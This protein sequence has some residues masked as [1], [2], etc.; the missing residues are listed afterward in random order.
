MF[1]VLTASIFFSGQVARA[2]SGW[3]N[4]YKKAQEEAKAGNKILLLNFTGSDWCGWCIKF[5]R[6]VLSQPQFKEFARNNLVLVELDF[7]RVKTQSAELQKQNRQLAQQYEVVG[8]PTIIAL[9]SDGQKLWEYDGYFAG[10]PE[11]FIAELEKL[12]KS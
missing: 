9:N 8:F 1:C 7:P 4:D 2:E 10:G 6:D 11:A 12:R 3:L 5:D